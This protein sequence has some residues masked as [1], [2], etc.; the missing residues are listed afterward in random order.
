[1][2]FSNNYAKLITIEDIVKVKLV[3]VKGYFK[4][5]TIIRLKVWSYF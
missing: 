5:Y 3:F 1:M 2:I 4:M